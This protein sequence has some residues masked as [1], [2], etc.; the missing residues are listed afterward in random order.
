M[1]YFTMK[2][3]RGTKKK[4]IIPKIVWNYIIMINQNKIFI[5]K[6]KI[7]RPIRKTEPSYTN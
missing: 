1:P 2:I 5:Y 7:L 3:L 6:L 4:L